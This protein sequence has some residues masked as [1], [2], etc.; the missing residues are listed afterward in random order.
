[1]KVFAIFLLC[2]LTISAEAATISVLGFKSDS[3][4]IYNSDGRSIKSVPV[5]TIGGPSSLEIKQILENGLCVLQSGNKD[6]IV[7]P[8]DL[9]LPS[10][11]NFNEEELKATTGRNHDSQS[12]GVN[13]IGEN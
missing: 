13:G 1:M 12:Y 4:K 10:G 5:Q 2:I 3:I 8:F 9:E 11:T 6:F 7:D